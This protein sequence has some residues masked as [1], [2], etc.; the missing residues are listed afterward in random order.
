MTR[1]IYNSATENG[2]LK[3]TGPYKI[4]TAD[5][6]IHGSIFPKNM[7]ISL[8]IKIGVT[9]IYGVQILGKEEE[10]TQNP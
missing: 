5:K 7:A 3:S 2:F 1:I 9:L 6:S 4:T 10:N 8:S